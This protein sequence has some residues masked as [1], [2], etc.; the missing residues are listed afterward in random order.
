M[1]IKYQLK[2]LNIL[3]YSLMGLAVLWS[4]KGLLEHSPREVVSGILTALC[5]FSLPI[6]LYYGLFRD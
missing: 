2:I 1:K 3:L 6:G 5:V 4:G